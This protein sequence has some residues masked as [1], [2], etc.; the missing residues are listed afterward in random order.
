[1][2]TTNNS[3]KGIRFTISGK[4]KEKFQENRVILMSIIKHLEFCGRQD[5]FKG[6]QRRT[7]HLVDSTMVTLRN[8]QNLELTQEIIHS[9][10]ILTLVRETRCTPLKLHK[11]IFR[12]VSRSLYKEIF[13]RRLLVSR[14]DHCFVSKSMKLQILQTLNSWESFCDMY[15]R[16]TKRKAT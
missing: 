16:E 2:R 5:Q 12:N 4:N 3:E 1:M 15:L 9:E 6:P 8:C 13:M 7:L 11:N 14:T 10:S